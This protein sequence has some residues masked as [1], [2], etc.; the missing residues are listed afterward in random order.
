MSAAEDMIDQEELDAET[1]ERHQYVTFRVGEELFA[2]DMNPVQEIIRVPEVIRVPLAPPSLCGL[3]NLRGKVLPVISLRYLFALPDTENDEAT[4]AVVI[5]VGQPIGFV[6]D[7][8]ASVIEVDPADIEDAG[9][10]RTTV[11]TSMLK[12]VI[13][14]HGGN[15]IMVVDFDLLV[16]QEYAHLEPLTSDGSL[17]AGGLLDD[18]FNNDNED[19]DPDELQLV[20]FVINQ[21]EYAAPIEDVKEIVQMPDSVTAVPR[22]PG[23]ILGLMNLRDQLLPLV[24]LRTLFALDYREPDDK[25][26]VIVVASGGYSI[27]IV[28]DSVSEVLRVTR[29]DVE[30]L[31]PMMARESELSD[32]TDICRLN[33][34]KRLVSILS[35]ER[36]FGNGALLETLE[37]LSEENMLEQEQDINDTQDTESDDDNQV[38]VFRLN[39]EEFAVPI[40]SI[41]EIVRIPDELIRVPKA[42]DFLEGVINLRG[43]VLP[44]IDLRTRLGLVASERNERQRIVVFLIHGVR[45]GFIVDQVTEVLRLPEG[46][47]ESSPKIAGEHGDLFTGM[48][49]LQESKRMIQLL[50]PDTL[51]DQDTVATL[52]TAAGGQ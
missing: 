19:E 52:E 27:G 22:S 25:S 41:Q 47:V 6:V 20:S 32:I 31:V 7:R 50:N 29:D 13:R 14:N 51:M 18:S 34:G 1:S 43:I 16:E 46:C 11:D 4:R 33:N 15:M 40:I 5:D 42:P 28:V 2:V 45:T 48:A 35:I 49:N 8:V 38:V 24:D 9:R 36:L 39:S 37:E 10:L 17:L 26:R 3:A 23:H 21:Q 44:V 30:G 12:G